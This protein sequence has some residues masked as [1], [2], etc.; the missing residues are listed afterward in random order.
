MSAAA[1][2]K[3]PAIAVPQT[4]AEADAL[5]KEYGEISNKIAHK[6]AEMDELL[7]RAK[8]AC[9]L[10][11]KPLQ[12]RLNVIFEQLQAWA[13]AHRNRLTEDGKSKSVQMPAGKIGW[14]MLPPS[15][16]FKKG[17][18]VEDILQAIKD[19]RLPRFIRT[20]EEVNKDR[21]LE[22][23][24]VANTIPGVKVGSAG[25][26]FFVEPFGAQLA[27]PKP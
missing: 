24:D 13:A 12:E 23:P 17:L 18:K 10:A 1:R 7:A 4:D 11:A 15:V 22:E 2:K 3:A 20:K 19:A 27:E 6:Q 21:M 9:E 8:V 16:R 26:D 25:E 14:R 5:L